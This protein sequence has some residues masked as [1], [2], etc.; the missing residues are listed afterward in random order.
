LRFSPDEI[1]QTVQM[2]GRHNLDIRAVTVGIDLLDC[3]GPREDEACESVREKVSSIAKRLVPCARV[4]EKKFG[5]PIINK[6]VSVTPVSSVIAPCVKGLDVSQGAQVAVKFARALDEAAGESGIDLI[7]GYSAIVPGGISHAD[8]CL[9]ESVPEA[10][11]GTRRVCGSVELATTRAGINL[12]AVCLAARKVV[13]LAEGTEKGFG[14][15]KFV[16]L[17]NAPDDIPFMAGAFHGFGGGESVVN[18]G[19][20][21]PGTVKCAVDSLPPGSDAVEVAEAVKRT[22]FKITRAGELVGRELAKSLGVQF[23]AVDLSLAPT[24]R[25]GD[26]VAEV[27]ESIGASVAGAHGTTAALYLLTNAVKTG[28]AMATRRAGGYSG[29]FIPVSEDS[30]MNEAAKNGDLSIDKLEALTSICSL[31]LDMVAVPG[32]TPWEAIA[33]MIADEMAIGVMNCKCTGARIIPVPGAKP[34]DEADFGG[35]FGK[36]CVMRAGKGS[37]RLVSRGGRIPAPIHGLRN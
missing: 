22:A 28:G 7:G 24:T 23:G 3:A 15:A 19:I 32:D 25:A 16:A 1:M 27:L 31:G 29:A 35:L 10:L 2:V 5:I 9:I 36:A 11:S 14:C 8:A 18:V 20:S 13:A 30:R 33:S 17:C 21:G 4:L 26:S 12:D 6:R 37:P 34:G